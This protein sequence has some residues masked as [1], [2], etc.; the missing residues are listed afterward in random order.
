MLIIKARKRLSYKKKVKKQQLLSRYRERFKLQQTFN[1][2]S[3]LH[4]SFVSTAASL[5]HV[6]KNMFVKFHAWLRLGVNFIL[7]LFVCVLLFLF[8]FY[9]LHTASGC[10]FDVST[11]VRYWNLWMLRTKWRFFLTFYLLILMF[12]VSLFLCELIKIRCF[13]N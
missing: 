8:S 3:Q 9:L 4:S 7:P 11:V 10:R 13:L 12:I 6:T 5:S 2:T 1:S